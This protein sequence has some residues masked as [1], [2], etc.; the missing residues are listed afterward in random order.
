MTDRRVKVRELVE[1]IDISHRN[2][3]NF[4]RTIEYEK[5][6]QDECRVYYH[7]CNRVISKQR[8]GDVST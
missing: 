5:A 3:F 1:A 8:F 4:A 7:K 2:D 6:R